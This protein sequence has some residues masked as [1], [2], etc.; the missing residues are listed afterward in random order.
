MSYL[1]QS[2][3]DSDGERAASKNEQSRDISVPLLGLMKNKYKEYI[4]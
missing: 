1:L 2:F 4:M 3:E